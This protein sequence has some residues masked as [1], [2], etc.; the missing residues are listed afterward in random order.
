MAFKNF[1]HTDKVSTTSYKRQKSI[2][3]NIFNNSS[4]YVEKTQTVYPCDKID[5]VFMLEIILFKMDN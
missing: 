2:I 1:K 4:L 5:S 3:I